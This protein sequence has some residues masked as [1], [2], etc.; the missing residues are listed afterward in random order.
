M[1]DCNKSIYARHYANITKPIGQNILCV[2]VKRNNH[3]FQTIQH[4]HQEPDLSQ[5]KVSTSE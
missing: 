2:V 5:V 3:D 4:I 1:N